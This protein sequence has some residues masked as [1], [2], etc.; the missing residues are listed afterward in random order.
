MARNCWTLDWENPPRE[1]ELS[2]LAAWRYTNLLRLV[3][4]CSNRTMNAEFL[5]WNEPIMKFCYKNGP[6][7]ESYCWNRPRA[8]VQ[9]AWPQ[10]YLAKHSNKWFF[11][12]SLNK[13]GAVI[14]HILGQVYKN[15]T[16]CH[17][18]YPYRTIEYTW[19]TMPSLPCYTYCRTALYHVKHTVEL[20][21]T[22]LYI[23]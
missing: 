14:I 1:L 4:S 6:G 16:I 10:E 19:V 21:F 7:E 2:P 11:H 8:F 3:L 15:D 20:P 13:S 22:M 18:D 5:H 17:M 23:L 12:W 9:I